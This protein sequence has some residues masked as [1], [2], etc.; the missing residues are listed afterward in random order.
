MITR[1]VGQ[2]CKHRELDES[3]HT[4]KFRLQENELS[5]VTTQAVPSKCTHKEALSI[6]A[7]CACVYIYIQQLSSFRVPMLWFI[8]LTVATFHIQYTSEFKSIFSRAQSLP[9]SYYTMATDG[10]LVPKAL[11]LREL[12]WS[13]L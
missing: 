7:L 8:N 13:H 12:Q 1:R 3:G 5:S 2:E 11:I 10:Y 4:F 9:F 6:N